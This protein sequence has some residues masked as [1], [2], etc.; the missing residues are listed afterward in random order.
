MAS[1]SPATCLRVM[2]SSDVL[3]GVPARF[4]IGNRKLN[5]LN[6]PLISTTFISISFRFPLRFELIYGT[7][8]FMFLQSVS[9][10]DIGAVQ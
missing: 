4:E 2:Y 5:G 1:S 9:N 8:V 10:S 7:C 3:P 6:S